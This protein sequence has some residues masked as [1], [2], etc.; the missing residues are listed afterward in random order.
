MIRNF[1]LS[2]VEHNFFYNLKRPN[3]HMHRPATHPRSLVGVSVIGFLVCMIAKLA[4]RIYAILLVA[5]AE[6]Y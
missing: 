4:S 5:V 1:M 2:R 6:I 3:L